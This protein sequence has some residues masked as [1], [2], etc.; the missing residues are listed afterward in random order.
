MSIL[1]RNPYLWVVQARAWNRARKRKYCANDSLSDRPWRTAEKWWAIAKRLRHRTLTPGCPG[2]NPGSLAGVWQGP[3]YLYVFSYRYPPW[4][5]SGKLI[6]GP[7]QGPVGFVKINLCANATVIGSRIL[8]LAIRLRSV[9]TLKSV[10]RSRTRPSGA[11]ISPRMLSRGICSLGKRQR[12][13]VLRLT[14]NQFPRGKHWRFNSSL[15]CFHD[16][17]QQAH[18]DAV[19]NLSV[20]REKTCRWY[21]LVRDSQIISWK[22]KKRGL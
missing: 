10:R 4:P 11:C 22:Y 20:S 8:L 2:S 17:A 19:N 18:V 13:A 1:R 16:T 14:V 7:S 6:K 15:P 3:Q 9:K 21:E 5:T 12:L